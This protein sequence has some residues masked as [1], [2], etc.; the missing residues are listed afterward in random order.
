MEKSLFAGLTV[1]DEDESILEDAGAFIGRDR[2]IIDRLLEIGAKTHR[3][4]G[5][6][7]I[8]DPNQVLGASAV[9]S[10][11]TLPGDLTFS[12]GYTL[13]DSDR[14][15]TLISPLVT[16]TTPPV[17][18]RPLSAPTGV[19]SYVAGA[20]PTDTYYYA[21]AFTD[22]EGGETPVGPAV[23]VEREPGFANAQ[24]E[25]SDLTNGMVAAGAS[26]WRLYRA[27]GGGDFHFLDSGSTDTY[28]DDGSVPVQPD[29][30]PLPEGVNNT[31]NDNGVLLRLPSADAR[32]S[33]ATYI[34]IYM[35]E[36]G[37]FSGDVFLQQFP[38]SSAGQEVFYPSITLF[39]Q[40][41][42]DT[43]NSIGG[44]SLIDPDNELL[45]WHW[46]RP[47]GYPYQ[48]GS[49]VIGD[50]RMTTAT[51]QLFGMLAASGSGATQWT[52]LPSGGAAA[53]IG[54]TDE[55][56]P[57]VNP[58]SQLEFV[59]SGDASVG[60][61]D[62][63]G[64]L[65]RVTIFS[66]SAAPGGGGGASAILDVSDSDGPVIFDRTYLEFVGS[67]S[68]GV[69]VT[70]LGGGSARVLLGPAPER[71]SGPMPSDM[72]VPYDPML[73]Q[74]NVGVP[75]ANQARGSMVVVPK[76]GLLR[77]LYVYNAVQSGNVE[78][79]VYSSEPTRSK[80]WSGG[81]IACP[82][83]NAWGYLGDPNL[84]VEEGDI[85]YFVLAADN[86]TATFGRAN[87][88]GASGLNQFPAGFWAGDGGTP[89]RAVTIA[90]FTPGSAPATIAEA[91]M[92]LT[93][94]EL[95]IIARIA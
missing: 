52:L 35:S 57:L 93:T 38:V 91:D 70:D 11:G 89:K 88:L 81:S 22:A 27:V 6:D 4:T 30:Q 51:G 54:V 1:L 62:E 49:G 84:A 15:E 19:I 59:A 87:H 76:T 68:A 37:D 55:D 67:G 17:I 60:V 94:F 42:P 80:L 9:A 48:L 64:G 85:L 73:V 14:G 44:A 50:V 78:G 92:V 33:E 77:D 12:V 25:L 24:V 20:L 40:Q 28:T 2:E 45:D 23:A 86:T 79:A 53:N 16:L 39:S 63:G 5:E 66:P 72:V 58:V 18:E 10:A 74:N 90:S 36:E 41:P 43:N 83:G 82:G 31:N 47:V 26:G 71:T 75:G 3:H 7:G 95:C 8:L 32:V 29:L 13:E 46:L 69:A 34:N 65:A 21:V 61:S 56:G